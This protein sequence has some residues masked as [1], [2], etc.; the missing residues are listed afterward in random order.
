MPPFV[1][2][3]PNAGPSAVRLARASRIPRLGARGVSSERR[4]HGRPH[5][6]WHHHRPPRRPARAA[7]RASINFRRDVGSR[8]ASWTGSTRSISRPS[9]SSPPA[10]WSRRSTSRRR[11]RKPRER[12]GKGDPKNYGDGAP[13]NI[14]HFLVARRLVEA[15][16][17]CV[18][19]EFRP[20]G[21]SLEQPLRAAHAPAAVRSGP[22]RAGRGS[23]RSA[24]STRTSRWSRGASLAARRTINKDGGPRPLAA[25]RLRRCSPAAAFRTGQVIGAT[26]RLGGEPTER[27]VH[28]GEVFATLYHWLGIDLSQPSPSPTSPAARSISSMAGCAHEGTHLTMNATRCLLLALVADRSRGKAREPC[29]STRPALRRSRCAERTR[30]SNCSSP[31]KLDDQR[32]ARLHPQGDLSGRARRDRERRRARP[33]LGRRRWRRDDHRDGGR[34][35]RDAR[36]ESRRHRRAIRRSISPTRSSRSSPRPAAT[37]AAA[38]ARPA[39]RTASSSRCSASSRRKITSTS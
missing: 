34:R 27:P 17:R 3:A 20:L 8:A 6:Q 39:G 18:T 21:F 32:R 25:R 37:A 13:R 1:G 16:A 28:F 4:G 15:G 30:A 35:R 19:I 7:A 22:Q 29:K 2:L 24:A 36:G 26:D 31:R 11:T 33:R 5:A 38:T 14:E 23:A 9:A 12:Y 10:S